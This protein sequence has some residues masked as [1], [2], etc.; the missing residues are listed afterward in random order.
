MYPYTV[1]LE[2]SFFNAQ[3]KNGNYYTSIILHALIIKENI[4]LMRIK[5]RVSNENFVERNSFSFVQNFVQISMYFRPHFCE[6]VAHFSF[7][8]C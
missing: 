5:I 4:D 6:N 2:F 8:F 7:N 1:G 3:T